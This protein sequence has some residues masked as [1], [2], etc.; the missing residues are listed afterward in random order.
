MIPV[1]RMNHA[2]RMEWHTESRNVEMTEW[3][4]AMQ[5]ELVFEGPMD[6]QGH[7]Q[8]MS[9]VKARLGQLRHYSIPPEARCLW[10][11]LLSAPPTV[12]HAMVHRRRF[13]RGWTGHSFLRFL[14]LSVRPQK[15]VYIHTYY[16]GKVCSKRKGWMGH[17]SALM[18]ICTVSKI[19]IPAPSY[20]IHKCS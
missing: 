11:T 8:N 13:S 17:L 16:T 3:S 20:E 2:R 9:W 14:H 12:L 18:W 1:W 19:G 15:N 6:A 5:M 4:L 7:S 10:Q